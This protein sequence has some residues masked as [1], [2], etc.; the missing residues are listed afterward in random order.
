MLADAAGIS[1]PEAAKAVDAF[2]LTPRTAW[3]SAEPGMSEKDWYPSRFRRRLSL[4]R[5]PLIQLDRENDP[6]VMVTPGIVRENVHAIMRAFH[7]GEIPSSQARSIEM[8]KWIGRT[9]N[10]QR[11][12]FNSTVAGRMQELGWQVDKEARL[13]KVLGH[14]LKRDYGDIDVLAWNAQSGRVLAIECKDLQYHKTI[15]EVAEQLSD[16]RGETRKDGKPDHLKRHLDRL[17]VLKAEKE[18]VASRLGITASIQIEGHLVFKNFVPM[19]FAWKHM[20][21]KVHLSLFKDLHLL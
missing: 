8:C 10:Q 17:E 19:Q 4:M 6:V 14:P 20:E 3:R 12:K 16:F 7:R 21:N 5:R 11:T 9:N 15:G 18:T 1:S 2:T 13:T